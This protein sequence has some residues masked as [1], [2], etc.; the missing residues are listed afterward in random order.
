MI[1][2]ERWILVNYYNTSR[3]YDDLEKYAKKSNREFD[4]M[5]LEFC[6]EDIPEIRLL[7]SKCL[8]DEEKEVYTSTGIPFYCN[9]SGLIWITPDDIKKDERVC[10]S[11]KEVVGMYKCQCKFVKGTLKTKKQAEKGLRKNKNAKIHKFFTVSSFKRH[12]FIHEKFNMAFRVK[13]CKS[14]NQPIIVY[15]HSGGNGGN[16]RK[17][18]EEFYLP[19]L[20]ILNKKC[21]I[22]IPQIPYNVPFEDYISGIKE[23]T[24]LIA[25]SVDADKNRIYAFGGSAGG[26]CTWQMA[27]NHPE[28]IACALPLSGELYELNGNKDVDLSH[29]KN[30]PMWISHS[31][32]DYI[33]PIDNDDYAVSKLKEIGAPIKYSRYEN[34]GHGV[35]MAYRFYLGEKWVDWMF[36]QSLKKR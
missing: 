8:N 36:S 24:E 21:T 28:F 6:D 14:K 4:A 2:I 34:C 9:K 31:A 12:V 23:L 20:K 15:F 35:K 25:A 10:I 3:Y 18:L 1:I 13:K 27:Y 16:S 22:I 29:M 19:Y 32:D 11:Y 5:L 26:R 17:A 30:L 33:L 7:L